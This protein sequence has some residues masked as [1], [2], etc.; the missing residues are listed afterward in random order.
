MDKGREAVEGLEAGSPRGEAIDGWIDD[1]TEALAADS[2]QE[3]IGR[4][5]EELAW[6]RWQSKEEEEAGRAG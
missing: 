5:L 1:V 3:L 4:H 2:D 6:L